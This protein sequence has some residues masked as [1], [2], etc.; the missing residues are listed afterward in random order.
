MLGLLASVAARDPEKNPHVAEGMH[1][2]SK[3]FW[4]VSVSI[5]THVTVFAVA[6]VTNA[7][8]LDRLDPGKASISIAVLPPPPAPS[9]GPEAGVKPKDPVPIVKKIAVDHVQPVEVHDEKP[10]KPVVDTDTSGG[11]EGKTKGPGTNSDGDPLDP[12]TCIGPACGP[13][14]APPVTLPEAPPPVCHDCNQQPAIVGPQILKGLRISGETAI[15][16][17][18]VVKTQMLRD[19]HK[20]TVGVFKLCLSAAGEVSSLGTMKSTKYAEYDG[21][22]L[23]G[24]RT[25]RYQPYLVGGVPTPVCSTVTFV[26]TME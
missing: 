11:G 14:T 23:A 20:R 13:P 12:G 6:F 1:P 21:R 18:D 19:D 22:L 4:I 5:A 15:A 16:P 17:P 26:Y 10:V 8:R 2:K 9:G 7:W 3:K 24:M 25:W